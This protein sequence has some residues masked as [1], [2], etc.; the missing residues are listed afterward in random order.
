MDGKGREKAMVYDRNNTDKMIT[1]CHKCHLNLDVSV[2]K[3]R[4]I[5]E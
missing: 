4:N 1:L 3:M 5:N 2:D